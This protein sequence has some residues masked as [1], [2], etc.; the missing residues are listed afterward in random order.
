LQLAEDVVQAALESALQAWK[1]QVP[2][3]P[4]AWLSKVAR[5]RA[6]DIIRRH[7]TERRFADDYRSQLES[8]WTLAATIEELL[9]AASAAENQLR[10][11][12]AICQT[13]LS[14]ETHVSLILKFLCGFGTDEIAA[15]FL[16]S[17]ET[18][19]K[20]L[21][22]GRVALRKLN[23]LTPVLLTKAEDP[24]L[25]S[26]LQSLYLLFN[27]GY[28]G[29]HP[30]TPTRIVLCQEALRLC[31]LMTERKDGATTQTHALMSLMCFHLARIPGRSDTDG[32][33]LR[34][35][36]QDR[37]TWDRALIERGVMHLSRSAFGSDLSTLHLEAGIA[38]QHCVAPSLAETDWDSILRHYDLLY[39][40]NS[41]P[42]IAISRALARAYSGDPSGA[43]GDA[44]ELSTEPVLAKYPFFWAAL[45]EIHALSGQ[46]TLAHDCYQ[47]AATLARN[48]AEQQAFLRNAR[49]S[50]G[51]Q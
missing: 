19:D 14:E 45:G 24:R 36:D 10:L 44:L 8:E 11:M 32:I 20:R 21:Q 17:V 43:L 16:C 1:F 29:S 7:N 22:R 46:S 33:Y 15:A 13:R 42:I 5:N 28:H 4:T 47:F 41:N 38:C 23:T 50:I 48:P 3:N 34:L 31:S 30:T 12:F 9:A 6:L 18:I 51:Q 2:D 49:Q 27:E 26:V 25:G 37:A 40:R 35:A 39:E